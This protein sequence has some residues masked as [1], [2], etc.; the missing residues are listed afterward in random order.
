ME[1][2]FS[3]LLCKDCPQIF[4]FILWSLNLDWF[5]F[6]HYNQALQKSEVIKEQ[7]MKPIHLWHDTGTHKRVTWSGSCQVKKRN[8]EDWQIWQHKRN[9]K[10]PRH[11]IIYVCKTSLFQPFISGKAPQKPKESLSIDYGVIQR[12]FQS[13]DNPLWRA[14]LQAGTRIVE[15][16]NPPAFSSPIYLMQLKEHWEVYGLLLC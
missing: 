1:R 8:Y 12:G 10:D 3:L 2:I 5:C 15:I 13:T 7:I 6:G 9:P 16:D 4:T 11:N 14:H